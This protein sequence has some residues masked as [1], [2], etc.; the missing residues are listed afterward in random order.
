[1]TKQTKTFDTTPSPE[2]LKAH[3]FAA[4]ATPREVFGA[5]LG[6]EPGISSQGD[7]RRALA[8]SCETG[9]SRS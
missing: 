5:A 8:R 3:G 1:M 7:F 6:E 2:W 9:D 4:T